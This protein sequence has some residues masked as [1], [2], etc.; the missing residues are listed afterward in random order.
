MAVVRH[1]KIEHWMM[2]GLTPVLEFFSSSSEIFLL[3]VLL[4]VYVVRIVLHKAP[5]MVIFM[6][7]L[8]P[9]AES[10]QIHPGALLITI[11]LGIECWFLPYQ[12]DSYLIAYSSSGG[13]AFSHRQGR[14]VMLLKVFASFLALLISIPY[15]K[16][17]GLIQ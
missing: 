12:T 5:V 14:K 3:V 8:V 16:A 2:G 17:L 13:N 4:L 6:V 1:L 10:L 15:W 7:G 9:W 11:L